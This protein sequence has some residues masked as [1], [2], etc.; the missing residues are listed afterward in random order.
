[1]RPHEIPVVLELL[2]RLNSG[3]VEL[4]DH[5]RAV[6]QIYALERRTSFS[7]QDT[8]GHAQSPSAK[9]DLANAIAGVTWLASAGL[10]HG[11]LMIGFS[12]GPGCGRITWRTIGEEQPRAR[13]R[14]RVVYVDEDDQELTAAQVQDRRRNAL[15]AS[16]STHRGQKMNDTEFSGLTLRATIVPAQVRWRDDLTHW[17]RL[18]EV[19]DE[20][21]ARVGDAYRVMDEIDRN[22]D[23]SPEGKDR[24][25]CKAAAEALGDFES[26]KTLSRA[27]ETVARVM[28]QWEEKVGLTVKP[29]SNI[30]EATVHAQIRDRLAAMEGSRM[31]FLVKNAGDPVIA[32]AVLMAPAFLSGLSDVEVTALKQRVERHVSPEIAEA[33]D[34]TVKAMGEAE[35]GWQRAMAKIGERAGIAKGRDGVWR[36]PKDV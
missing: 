24:Q 17:Q 18:H 33:R 30:A 2:P 12:E 11:K 7:G 23:L 1:V 31:D 19:V 22:P 26:S 5:E 8:I 9:D 15:R 10:R 29:A 20:A 4:L 21:R 28:E 36:D 13:D 14:V 34:A 35:R 3:I 27:R 25:R 6:R 16:T 32:S